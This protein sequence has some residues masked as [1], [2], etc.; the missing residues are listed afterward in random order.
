MRTKNPK[1]NTSGVSGTDR[2]SKWLVGFTGRYFT[3]L[4]LGPDRYR[5]RFFINLLATLTVIGVFYWTI[6]SYWD[7]DWFAR[8]DRLLEWLSSAMLLVAGLISMTTG[9][10]LVG[11]SHQRVGAAQFAL[12]LILL[13][14]FLEEISWGQRLFDWPT[15]HLLSNSNIQGETNLH[16]IRVFDRLIYSVLM[17]ASVLAL[18]GAIGR[19]LL[20]R[21]GRVTT[22]DFFAPPLVLV[23]ALLLVIAWTLDGSVGDVVRGVFPYAP[24]GSEFPEVVF[25]IF[26]LLFAW[27]NVRR[28]IQIRKLR[29][30]LS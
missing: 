20:H 7:V 4:T 10:G 6:H 8:E 14:V 15:P 18:F 12:G 1:L 24:V 22:M 9:L 23:P 5:A 19:I 11:V 25:G 29:T 17:W 21:A 30:S 13:L 3:D 2:L 27:G 28:V 26:I 16:N